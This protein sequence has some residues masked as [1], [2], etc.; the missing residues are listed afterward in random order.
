MPTK[1]YSLEILVDFDRLWFLMGLISQKC[2]IW[3]RIAMKSTKNLLIRGVTLF[4]C[5]FWI[6]FSVFSNSLFAMM[7]SSRENSIR[8]QIWLLSIFWVS[9][10]DPNAK[11][12]DSFLPPVTVKSVPVNRGLR[13]IDGLRGTA[14]LLGNRGLLVAVELGARASAD[15]RSALRASRRFS[16]ADFLELTRRITPARCC[17]AAK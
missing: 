4:E 15:A 6:I 13:G 2:P 11:I 5:L 3:P 14:G 1:P 10:F 12:V 8:N 9:L 17:C 7:Y 16:I